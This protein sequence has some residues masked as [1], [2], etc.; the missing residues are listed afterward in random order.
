MEITAQKHSIE[1]LCEVLSFV[2]QVPSRYQVTKP[3]VLR[4]RLSPGEQ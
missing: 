1:G 2:E 4:C 3:F